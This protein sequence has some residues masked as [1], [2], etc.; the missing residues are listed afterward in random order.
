MNVAT[1]EVRDF[2]SKTTDYF[3]TMT[4]PFMKSY[5]LHRNDAVL[6]SREQKTFSGA[7]ARKLINFKCSQIN[8][9]IPSQRQLSWNSNQL[10]LHLTTHKK[11]HVWN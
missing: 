2:V 6:N 8:R 5:L 10:I 4:P 11:S 3:Q 1:N 7:L 9:V